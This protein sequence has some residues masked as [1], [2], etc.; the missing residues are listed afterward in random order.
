MLSPLVEKLSFRI[1]RVSYSLVKR[2][3]VL[4]F[5]GKYVS[6]VQRHSER[7]KVV[8]VFDLSHL[9]QMK[10]YRQVT[11]TWYEKSGRI[12]LVGPVTTRWISKTANYIVETFGEGGCPTVVLHLPPSWRTLMWATGAGF[13]GA[14]TIIARSEADFATVSTPDLVVTSCPETARSLASDPG[15]I[16]LLQAM[17]PFALEWSGTLPPG[18]ADAIGEVSSQ[19]DFIEFSEVAV[20]LPPSGIERD[21]THYPRTV[22]QLVITD[23]ADD[24][25][26]R[27]WSAWANDSA[28]LW[29]APGLDQKRILT[30]ERVAE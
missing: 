11:L 3:E 30:Q 10:D 7:E 24:Y 14:T 20:P 29:I 12:E 18:V 9:R 26:P 13:A 1:T 25:I 16:V 4:K 23:G 6:G 2:N 17:E 5:L 21:E 19:P 22:G 8:S 15:L 27:I 28:A